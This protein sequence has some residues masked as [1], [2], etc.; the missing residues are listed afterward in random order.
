MNNNEIT[1]SENINVSRWFTIAPPLIAAA[2]ILIIWQVGAQIFE[3]PTYIAPS[4]YDIIK[5]FSVEYKLLFDN[6]LPTTLESIAG[7]FMGNGVAIVIAIAFVHNKH[8]EKSFYPLAVF[9]NTIPVLAIAPILVLI[10][11]NGFTPKVV[12]AALICFFPTLVNMVR[13]L[14]SI[15]PNLLDLMR[16]LSANDWEIFWKI[17]IH[18]SLPYLFAALKIAATTSVIGAIVGEWIGSDYGL[19]ALILEATYNFRSPLLYATLFMASGLSVVLFT[20]VTSLE[21]VFIKWKPEST[22]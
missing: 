20:I 18:A 8:I 3:M 11:G 16:I 14:E 13:G 12:I 17:R 10:F 22:R 7:F 19:G 21:Y 6:L 9:I 4:P 15:S 2:G 1:S 5:E